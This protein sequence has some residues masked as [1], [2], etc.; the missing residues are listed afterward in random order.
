[1]NKN[2]KS[3]KFL[4]SSKIQTLPSLDSLKS[5]SYSQSSS[6]KK[7]YYS[8]SSISQSELSDE[9]EGDRKSE[10]MKVKL[11]SFWNSVKYGKS[12]F[13]TES[14]LDESSLNYFR[15]W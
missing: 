11:M 10:K 8:N 4:N 15:L 3:N 12:F 5:K 1:M 13:L 14:R 6:F 2:L 7:S 9:E